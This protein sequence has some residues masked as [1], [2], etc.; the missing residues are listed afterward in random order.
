MLHIILGIGINIIACQINP[1][2]QPRRDMYQ[3]HPSNIPQITSY[4][5]LLQS[6]QQAKTIYGTRPLLH[7]LLY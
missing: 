2:A 7:R 6:L 4:T 5:N 1:P 3:P